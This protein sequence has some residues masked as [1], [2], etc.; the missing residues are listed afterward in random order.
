MKSF[1]QKNEYKIRRDNPKESLKKL[2]WARDAVRGAFLE[3][4]GKNSPKIL[5]D[6]SQSGDFSY[7]YY[8]SGVRNSQ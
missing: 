5:Y 6:T 4:I 7:G 1:D 3:T 8:Q 2:D